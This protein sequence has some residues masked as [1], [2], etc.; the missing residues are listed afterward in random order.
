M[1]FTIEDGRGEGFIAG[2]NSAN[3]LLT[4]GVA[5]TELDAATK[6]GDG[7]N[8]LS[9]FFS[10]T[11]AG[12]SAILSL[13]NTRPN[14][15][16]LITDLLVSCGGSNAVGP[17]RDVLLRVYSQPTGGTLLSAGTAA[18]PVQR[19]IGILT[20]AQATCFRL[21]AS[22]QT[23]TGG[24]LLSGRVLQDAS[25]IDINAGWVLPTGTR[26]GVSIQPPAGNTAMQILAVISFAYLPVDGG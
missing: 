5:A 20:P 7:Y 16:M 8:V 17:P 21:N 1:A 13:E 10:L 2:V 15:Q 9:T 22:G 6:I 3:Q 24:T 18:V 23:L 4:A 25:R 14:R 11:T 12:E 26:I 19:N